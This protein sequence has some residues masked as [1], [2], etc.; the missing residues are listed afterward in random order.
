MPNIT[1]DKVVGHNIYAK[2]SVAVLGSDLKTVKKTITNGGLIGNV[3]SWIKGSDGQIYYMIYLNSNDYNNFD[4]SYVLHDASKISLP[5]LPTIMEEIQR[6]ADQEKIAQKGIVAFY[7]EKY[8]PYI[9]GAVVVAIAIP[10]LKKQSQSKVG[11][12]TADNKRTAALVGAGI[13]LWYITRKKLKGSVEIGP[14]DPG[15]YVP[16]ATVSNNDTTIIDDSVSNP[17]QSESLPVI[18]SGGG[19]GEVFVTGGGSGSNYVTVIDPEMF[20]KLYAGQIE[21]VGPFPVQ[22]N[23]AISGK[24]IDLGSIKIN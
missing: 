21:Y 15:E 1:I 11:A 12:M 8:A 14:L 16:D 3:W 24:K 10:A 20:A 22:Y 6:L 7:I 17:A 18:D 4:P 13:L 23:Q 19:S 2:G 5:D 9:V